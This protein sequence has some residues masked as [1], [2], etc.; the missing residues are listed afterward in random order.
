MLDRQIMAMFL[1]SCRDLVRSWDGRGWTD[2]STKRHDLLS[3]QEKPLHASTTPSSLNI[4]TP[5]TLGCC[6]RHFELLLLKS[7]LLCTSLSCARDTWSMHHGFHRKASYLPRFT[8]RKQTTRHKRYWIM[9]RS[10]LSFLGIVVCSERCRR[11]DGNVT[12]KTRST[13]RRRKQHALCA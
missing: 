13:T 8:H 3:N 6:K 7:S 10:M 9:S 5:Q 4:S 1:P 12:T 2:C 11:C